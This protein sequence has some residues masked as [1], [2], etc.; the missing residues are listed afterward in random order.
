LRWKKYSETDSEKGTFTGAGASGK[1]GLIEIIYDKLEIII[2]TRNV[3]TGIKGLTL[4][5]NTRRIS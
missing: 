1:N 2:L 4:L 5:L 3:L